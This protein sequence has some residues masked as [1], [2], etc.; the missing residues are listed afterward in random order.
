[1]GLASS[2]SAAPLSNQLWIPVGGYD[3]QRRLAPTILGMNGSAILEQQL[4]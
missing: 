3:V 2:H 4:D 1:M